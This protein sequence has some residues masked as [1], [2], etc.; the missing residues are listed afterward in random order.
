M[1]DES[2]PPWRYMPTEARTI[3]KSPTAPSDQSGRI[4]WPVQRMLGL[5]EQESFEATS[6]EHLNRE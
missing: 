6:R 4:S 2:Q 1:N 3:W 5:I